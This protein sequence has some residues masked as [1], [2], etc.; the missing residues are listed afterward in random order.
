[1]RINQSLLFGFGAGLILASM[2]FGVADLFG[3][4]AVSS[5][6]SIVPRPDGFLS[7]TQTAASPAQTTAGQNSVQQIQ[8]Q[9]LQSPENKQPGQE[10]EQAQPAGTQVP[11]DKQPQRQPEN[12]TVSVTIKDGMQAAEIAELLKGKGVI[13]DVNAFLNNAKDQTRNIRVGTYELP[14][15]GDYNAVLKII[16]S[17][18]PK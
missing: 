9:P 7:N 17:E 13:A 11:Q 2:I 8:A 4:S 15:N 16:T 18:R 6:S 12:K 14:T 3:S 10:Q 1:M 5:Q